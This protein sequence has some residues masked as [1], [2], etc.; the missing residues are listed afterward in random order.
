MEISS[1]Q[2]GVYAL[3]A[4]FI[5]S[6]VAIY[7]GSFSSGQNQTNQIDSSKIMDG[8]ATANATLAS[9]DPTIKVSDINENSLAIIKELKSQGLVLQQI[10]TS[11]VTLLTISDSQ[12]IPKISS[13]LESAGA[14]TYAQ[15]TVSSG[16]IFFVSGSNS[17]ILETISYRVKI[18]PIFAEGESFPI[19]FSANVLD[20]ELYS[21]SNPSIVPEEDFTAWVSPDSITINSSSIQILVP[22]EN[23]NQNIQ[24]FDLQED[25]SIN[26]TPRSYIIFQTPVDAQILQQLSLS[27]PA[28]LTSLQP[29]SFSIDSSFSGA[30]Q[31][32]N[33][34]MAYGLEPQ[35]PPSVV[36]LDAKNQTALAEKFMATFDELNA[37]AVSSYVLEAQMPAYLNYEGKQYS[38]PAGTILIESQNPPTS[39]YALQ[40]RATPI[41]NR[42]AQYS[43][44]S[45]GPQEGQ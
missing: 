4:V 8:Y 24:N 37:T 13:R 33:D 21:Y 3:I 18:Q 25:E 19:T 36:Y 9:Y 16:P 11:D 26:Y 2:F 43:V 34:L 6:T 22:W 17:L 29:T 28:Y 39:D 15:A 23:R 1:K 31:I 30:Q 10:K 42:I 40:I 5:L 20:G 41:S 12:E 45:Y 7:F 38:L 27:K 44:I 35:F 14:T 32:T